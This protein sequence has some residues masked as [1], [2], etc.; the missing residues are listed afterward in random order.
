MHLPNSRDVA[1][2]EG[3]RPPQCI[4]AGTG[5]MGIERIS[6][7]RHTQPRG[8]QT[9]RDRHVRRT[10]TTPTPTAS[11][12]RERRGR[13]EDGLDGFGVPETELLARR[14]EEAH[15]RGAAR[16]AAAPVLPVRA[17]LHADREPDRVLELHLVDVDV[18][19]GPLA[20]VLLVGDVVLERAPEVFEVFERRVV[21]DG[22]V[23]VLPPTK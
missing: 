11:S 17:V 10:P 21:G 6:T 3:H 16:P 2:A 15:E 20:P 12:W 23:G 1:T 13:H 22:E 7:G 5:R 9:R 19:V 4:P 14:L 8:A 18:H